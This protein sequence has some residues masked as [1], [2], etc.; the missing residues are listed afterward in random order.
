MLEP[1]HGS[2]YIDETGKVQTIIEPK[3][4]QVFDTI[5][6]LITHVYLT[7]LLVMIYNDIEY[8]LTHTVMGISGYR[9]RWYWNFGK[10]QED[11]EVIFSR[12]TYGTIHAAV[13]AKIFDGQSVVDL[14][15]IAN[16]D[17]N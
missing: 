3:T 13:T 8:S 9:H 2:T 6:D 11:E 14:L 4:D 12:P 16:F 15:S 17:K 7:G 1:K 10:E 5:D